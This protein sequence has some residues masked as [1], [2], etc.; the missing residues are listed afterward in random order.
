MRCDAMLCDAADQNAAL[1]S[2]CIMPN[3]NTCNTHAKRCLMPNASL[4]HF[5]LN[6]VNK[7]LL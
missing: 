4:S 2:K 6:L 5:V 1:T 3:L 7:K